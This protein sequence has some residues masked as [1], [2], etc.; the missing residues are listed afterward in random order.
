MWKL[1]ASFSLAL[2][3]LSGCANSPSDAPAL[4]GDSLPVLLDAIQNTNDAGS[5]RMA[6]DLTFTS[7]E[8]TV[9]VT[10][11]V[12]YVMDP[13]DPT[14][15]R[16]RVVLDIPSLGMIPGGAVE[17]IIGKG[18]VV[19]VRAPMLASFI[20]A[21]TPWIKIDPSALPGSDDEFGAATAAA[22]PAAILAAIK[23]ALTVEEV[24]TDSVD[25]SDATQY[26][27][28]VD[29][30]KLLPLLADMASDDSKPTDA[31][32]KDAADQLEK[33]GLETLPIDLWVDGDGFLK[34]I[35]LAPDL[36]NVD[37]ELP[38]SAFSL[39]LT[40]S[41]IGKNISIDVPPASQVTDV[42][43]LLASALEPVTS[44]LA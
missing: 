29:L 13:A 14:S 2:L 40:F 7:P 1:L 28:T 27:A 6:I 4:A 38:G 35:Q 5:A 17:M 36:S 18:P 12:E 33:V 19:Y 26:R 32:M 43:D 10:G 23:G 16:E 25:G 9:K 22:N 20:P 42:S 41:D 11:V 39:T 30:V 15:L 34:R 8:Q 44:S 37:P 24:G 21:T 3:G 31:E